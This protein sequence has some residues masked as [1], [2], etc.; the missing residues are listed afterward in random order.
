MRK[1]LSLFVAVLVATSAVHTTAGNVDLVTARRTAMDF[2]CSGSVKGQIRS[3]TPQPLWTHAEASEAPDG[4]AAYYI[5]ST[6]MGYVV[7]AGDD[8]ARPILA[9]S[10]Y[11]LADMDELPAGAQFWLELYK[12]QIEALQLQPELEASAQSFS[13][14]WNHPTTSILPMLHTE[15]GQSSPFNYLCPTIDGQPGYAGCSAVALAQVMRYWQYPASCD[16]LPAYTTHTLGLAVDALGGTDLD[17]SQMLDVY[18]LSGN[19]TTGQRDAAATLLRYVG[20]AEHMDYKVQGSNA[21]EQDI[22]D[23]INFFGYDPGACY[24]EKSSV[25]GELYY[26]DEVWAAML[27]NELSKGRPV[28]YCGYAMKADST[29]EGHAFNVDG[30]DAGSD[31]YHVNFGWRGTGDGH[32]ALNAFDLVFYRFDIGQM[33]FL[34]VMPPRYQPILWVSKEQLDMECC[35]GDTVTQKIY[36]AGSDL[37]ADITVAVNATDSV[38]QIT[39]SQDVAGNTV[40]TVMFAPQEPGN[41]GASLTVG[42][43][44][45][46]SVPVTI[47]GTALEPP[48][49]YQLGDTNHDGTVDVNDLT[50]LIDILLN[51]VAEPCPICCDVLPDG[52]VDISDVS[53]LVDLIL[54]GSGEE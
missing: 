53:A 21:D 43:R 54:N 45:A 50:W 33:M 52:R 19:Y 38:F 14:S 9:Y 46:Q 42:S 18:P 23:A 41:Y 28:I 51:N 20:Q 31:T 36:V 40:I 12:R 11:P 10:D 39:S 7:V 49:G 24:V 34:N 16:P 8:R 5:V 37:R 32:Y 35:V 48:H 17:W 44:G 4:G 1:A 13:A 2:L 47:G 3:M 27:Y 30:Y 22:L 29:L 6:D 25:D 26:P 15:W